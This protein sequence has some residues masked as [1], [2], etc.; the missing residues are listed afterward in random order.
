MG[1]TEILTIKPYA[2]LLTM[3]GDQLIKDEIIAITELVK[4]SYDADAEH[5]YVC[6]DHFGPDY[7]VNEYSKIIIEDDGNGMD[8]QI[9]TNA[10]MNPATPTKLKK[11]RA[12]AT[13]D[14]GRIMQGEKGI[15][16]FAIFKL[17]RQIQI[18]TRRQKRENKQFIDAPEANEE[19]VLTYD[20]SKYDTDFL[21][22]DNIEDEI[23][24]EDLQVKL[25][26]RK[27]EI[28]VTNR[29][30]SNNEQTAW[31]PYGTRIVIS[32]LNG[33]WTKKKIEEVYLS[34]IRMQPI[35]QEAFTSD[36]KASLFVN[37]QPYVSESISLDHLRMLLENK[38]V[39]IVDGCYDEKE[40]EIRFQ[41]FDHEKTIPYIFSINNP[42]MKGISPLSA[43]LNE[44]EKRG[45]ECG[46]FS[47]K[48]Y[49][50]D[51]DVSTRDKNTRYYLD[52][53]EKKSIKKH[54]VY[55]Y[56][57]NIRV[58]PY[59][60]PDDD[61]L[62]I[63]ITRG[64]EQSGRLFSNDQIVGYVTISQ[65]NNPKLK[66]K[67]NREGLIEE[68]HAREDLIKICQL[69]LRYL[70]AKPYAQYLI[71]KKRR[72]EEANG[73]HNQPISIIREADNS[74]AGKEFF[75]RFLNKYG[76][77]KID[78]FTD[79]GEELYKTDFF[80]NFEKAY[81]EERDVF[82]QKI[83]TTENLA[84]IGL[85]AETAYH[86]SRLLL[87]EIRNKISSLLQVYK[88]YPTD[89]IPQRQIINDLSALKDQIYR[90]SDLMH[91][92]Q[93]LFPS[94]NNKRKDIRLYQ[95]ISKVKDLYSASMDKAGIKCEIVEKGSIPF[96][97]SCTDA[98]LLQVFINLFDNA[99]YW[100]KTVGEDR[101]IR[102]E[103]NSNSNEVLFSDSGPGVKE[104]DLPYIFE[105]FYSGKGEDGKGLGLYIARQL[106]ERYEATIDILTAKELIPLN[107][108]TFLLTFKEKADDGLLQ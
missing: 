97:V 28:I 66:D 67:T 86:D 29:K 12:K 88:Q 100:L 49:I 26:T 24:L 70:R 3:L 72:R 89:Q 8:K 87:H 51:L 5:V 46:S 99:L 78:D 33:V 63:D 95:L 35:F 102:I 42:E 48:F 75:Q 37:E 104:R 106:L 17:G 105:A 18:T 61:W 71:D 62:L 47:Y 39:F 7:S 68:G 32:N 93:K 2:R 96:I 98:V 52:L 9:L 13:T 16:R 54:R 6:F 82:E 56:R 64:T 103:L 4:N 19:Y 92:L 10:W 60:D 90:A 44:I 84:A 59:G 45:T 108:A 69:I 53:E 36:F 76:N 11:K 81:I 41:L 14:K 91:S 101:R 55:L 30:I 94:T 65:K 21:S 74:S 83:T 73:T 107:G 22:Y 57:D 31:K 38:S 15:G 34:L 80:A 25:Q 85:S 43:Y 1:K 77:V 20:F 27:P 23:F 50:M 79:K 58:L 40:K